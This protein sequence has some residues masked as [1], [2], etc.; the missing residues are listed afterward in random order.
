MSDNPDR[1]GR[2]K[3]YGSTGIW[4][5]KRL[6][7]KIELTGTDALSSREAIGVYYRWRA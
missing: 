2:Q 6:R 5:R 1:A 4:E 3:A 7:L